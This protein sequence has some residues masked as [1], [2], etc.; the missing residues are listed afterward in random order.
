MQI[1]IPDSTNLE[2]IK[3]QIQVGGYNNLHILAD[4]DRTLTYGAIHGIKTPSIISMLRDGNYLSPEYA[5]KAHALFDKYNRIELDPS[6]SIAA[7]KNCHADLVAN[8]QSII[9]RFGF[10]SIRSSRYSPKWSY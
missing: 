2:F 3:K 7:K 9:D 8:P 1:Q 5:Q 6:I 4:F 10:K